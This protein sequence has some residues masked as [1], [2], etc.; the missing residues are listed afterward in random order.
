WW[1]RME[2]QISNLRF[3][4]AR[5]GLACHKNGDQFIG[6]LKEW[7]H[8]F[9]GNQ[10]SSDHQLEPKL[11]LIGL[12]KRNPQLCDELAPRACA[13]SSSLVCTNRCSGAN[14]LIRDCAAF[15]RFR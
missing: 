3:Q 10:F 7:L 2:L 8:S 4:I 12:F 6:F 14:E 13:P 9:S 1:Q 15:D 11:R 5:G